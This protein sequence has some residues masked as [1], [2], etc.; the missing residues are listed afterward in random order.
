[1]Q[2]YED[3]VLYPVWISTL[4]FSV[5]Y[6]L[7][8]ATGTAPVDGLT[9]ASGSQAQ[10]KAYA[11]ASVTP[12]AGKVF[13]GWRS[14]V[15]NKIYYPNS[16]ITMT[17]NTT[18]TAVWVYSAYMVTITYNGNGGATSGGATTFTGGAV[19]NT[20]HT[21][22]GNS[23]LNAGKSFV[24]WNTALDGSGTWYSERRQRSA[25][26]ECSVCARHAVCHLGRP[27]VLRQR[28]GKSGRGRQRQ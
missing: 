27:D 22:Q 9:Y 8:Y 15:D 14:S 6:S 23:F 17:E 7:G 26:P 16:A 24:G 5:T 13:I 25:G 1:M 4:N 21:V 2:I 19:N 11:A 18:L 28:D 10:V 20:Y 12:P 3:V